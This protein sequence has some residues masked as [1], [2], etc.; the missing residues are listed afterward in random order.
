[1]KFI[2]KHFIFFGA[3]VFVALSIFS[4]KPIKIESNVKTVL[5]HKKSQSLVCPSLIKLPSESNNTQSIYDP[6]LD[7]T[8]KSIKSSI[9]GIST[10][11]T[12]IRNMEQ[13]STSDLTNI[14]NI[15]VENNSQIIYAKKS[16]GVKLSAASY[17]QNNDG[18]TTGVATSECIQ[19]K[20]NFTF[21]GGKT[22][23]NDA[24]INSARLIMVNPYDNS[25]EINISVYNVLG[26]VENSA[27]K[28][29]LIPANSERSILIE[30]IIQN[31]DFFAASISVSGSSIA[32]FF[33]QS[34]VNAM[35]SEGISFIPDSS[36][37]MPD[38][39]KIIIPSVKIENSKGT[40][41]LTLFAPKITNNADARLTLA[42]YNG[43][44]KFKIPGFSN[45]KLIPGT[46]KS[47]AF[48]DLPDNNYTVVLTSKTIIYGSVLTK[49]SNNNI[50][51]FAYT[52]TTNGVNAGNIE[53]PSEM[54]YQVTVFSEN[55]AKFSY[56]TIDNSG[57]KVSNNNITLKQNQLVTLSDITGDINGIEFL[58]N[59][60]DVK[61]YI[62]VNI[63]DQNG[64]S[65]TP[66]NQTFNDKQ[67]NEQI[68]RIYP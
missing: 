64:C 12:T 63:F 48:S 62:S 10:G 1:V 36:Y 46:I 22:Y 41:T 65:Y 49:Y 6:K 59:N 39:N 35:Q 20:N 47:I 23:S 15:P 67:I 2:K 4:L 14:I 30:G 5:L 38:N 53:V 40:S 33:V 24:K 68:K 55:N 66:I 51:D 52:V 50:N 7:P 19:T 26:E 27:L 56:S 18:E 11:N 54:P 37:K 31:Q 57:N 32:A 58:S 3:I 16:N 60:S 45:I 28:N 25:A 44:K 17:I 13:T 42:L 9:K 43:S 21:V 8:S 29:I 34:N 61:F